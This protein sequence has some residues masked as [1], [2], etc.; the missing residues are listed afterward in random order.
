MIHVVNIL[1]LGLKTCLD[2]TLD[3]RR[4]CMMLKWSGNRKQPTVD[5]GPGLMS[6]LCELHKIPE[7]QQLERK[8]LFS[9]EH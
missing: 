2:A 7:T 9:P 3:F 5:I 1:L 8:C 4:P 6:G